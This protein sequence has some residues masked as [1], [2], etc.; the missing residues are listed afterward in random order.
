MAAVVPA[1]Q[2]TSQNLTGLVPG[3]YT[4]TIEAA[5][6]EGNMSDC[7][8]ELTVEELLATQDVAFEAGLVVY[9]NP[10]SD[11]LHIASENQP[12]NSIAVYDIL[13]KQYISI[14]QINSENTRIDLSGLSQGVYFIKINNLV[15][16]R[17]IRK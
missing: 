6:A 10:T 11:V 8:F 16:K 14:E 1:G 3:T 7:S 9:P 4:V 15:V 5:D 13:G 17:I 2:T 12:I